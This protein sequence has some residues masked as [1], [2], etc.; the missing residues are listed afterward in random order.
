MR[1]FQLPKVSNGTTPK[2]IRI[3]NDMVEEIESAIRGTN[4]N[5]SQFIVAAARLAL[6]SLQEQESMKKDSR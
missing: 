4:V 2:T 3:P 1:D 5:F 6:D